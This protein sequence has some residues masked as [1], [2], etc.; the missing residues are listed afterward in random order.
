MTYR[1]AF[2]TYQGA[3]ELTQS[4]SEECYL[5]CTMVDYDF[6]HGIIDSLDAY[7]D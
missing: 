1:E 4:G 3:P 5:F 6:E 7:D 2:K